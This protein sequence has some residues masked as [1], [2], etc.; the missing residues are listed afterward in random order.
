[1]ARSRPF[2]C[3]A[4]TCVAAT[5][6]VGSRPSRATSTSCPLRYGDEAPFL[7]DCKIVRRHP[8]ET[9]LTEEDIETI[10][11]GRT[12]LLRAIY[13][14]PCVPDMRDREHALRSFEVTYRGSSKIDV[15]ILRATLAQYE[16]YL[17]AASTRQCGLNDGVLTSRGQFVSRS[18][19]ER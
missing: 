6:S 7:D 17:A 10:A 18:S 19:I 1:M 8:Q 13:L 3:L 12:A 15:Y 2:A 5:G 4:G 9:L 16:T 14:G 11:P